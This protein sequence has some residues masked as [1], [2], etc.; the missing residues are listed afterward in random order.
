MNAQQFN[1]TNEDKNSIWVTRPYYYFTI[2][3][4]RMLW[5]KEIKLNKERMQKFLDAYNKDPKSAG[6]YKPSR[7]FFIYEQM[8]CLSIPTK[9]KLRY[10]NKAAYTPYLLANVLDGDFEEEEIEEAITIFSR[11]LLLI[12]IEEDHT[13]TMNLFDDTFPG[14]GTALNASDEQ[15]NDSSDVDRCINKL[16]EHNYITSDHKEYSLFKEFFDKVLPTFDDLSISE[17]LEVIA[18]FATSD[19]K[20]AKT[21]IKSPFKY[22]E[23]AFR[24]AIED[25]RTKKKQ[26]S[27]SEDCQSTKKD[28]F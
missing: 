22:F 10:T 21:T 24:K 4:I 1:L 26:A 5:K 9:G 13:I 15:D 18:I 11:D 17:V 3:Q 16:I 12:T 25:L 19:V 8:L 20:K 7:L 2:P 14:K 6:V 23:P 28:W 27:F